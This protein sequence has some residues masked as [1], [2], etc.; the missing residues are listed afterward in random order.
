MKPI[1]FD[2]EPRL[3]ARTPYCDPDEMTPEEFRISFAEWVGQ[4]WLHEAEVP[5]DADSLA[6]FDMATLVPLFRNGYRNGDWK[7]V[8]GGR[9]T[10]AEEYVLWL[11]LQ[12]KEPMAIV[13]NSEMEPLESKRIRHQVAMPPFELGGCLVHHLFFFGRHAENTDKMAIPLMLYD[14]KVGHVI[15]ARSVDDTKNWI[16]Y[17]D[18]TWPGGKSMLCE[19]ENALGIKATFYGKDEI[20]QWVTSA[21]ALPVVTYGILIQQSVLE[22]W[23][24]WAT[25]ARAQMNK[26]FKI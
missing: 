7:R 24:K 10:T 21:L 23:T 5:N 3:E 1:Y 26:Y 4:C 13:L 25:Q 22:I 8:I 15:T 14:G 18:P 6:K 9:G 20:G 2:G 19:G 17:D 12:V 11:Q 16:G